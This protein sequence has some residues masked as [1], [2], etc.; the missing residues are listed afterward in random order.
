MRRVAL[1]LVSASLVGAAVFSGG[2]AGAAKNAKKVT[3]C[4]QDKK[5]NEN[6]AK[7]F[8]AFL[9]GTV[10]ADQVKYV[11]NGDKVAPFVQEGLQEAA[12]KGQSTSDTMTLTFGVDATCDGKKAAT[13]SYDLALGVARTP[14]TSALKGAGLSFQG[15]AI[16]DT[17]KGQWY[18]S[19][20]TIC[21]LIAAGNSERGQ[22]CAVAA[23]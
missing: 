16:L 4:K 15:D 8:D 10:V 1:L 11:Q 3:S 6:I 12:D 13:F 5:I 7:A 2:P 9:S 18:I 21:D 22:R 14:P 23:G 17:K 20:L 19:A